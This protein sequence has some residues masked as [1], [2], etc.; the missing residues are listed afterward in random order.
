MIRELHLKAGRWEMLKGAAQQDSV[1]VSPACTGWTSV[2]G[3]SALSFQ[4]GGPKL[5]KTVPIAAYTNPFDCQA[6]TTS[7]CEVVFP[8]CCQ[9]YEGTITLMPF[10]NFH[11]F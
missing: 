1:L 3:I 5:M 10:F 9:N 2:S 7:G 4:K 6:A 11:F 8:C